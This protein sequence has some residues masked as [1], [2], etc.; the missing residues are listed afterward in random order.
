[1]RRVR[2]NFTP[3]FQVLT[4]GFLIAAI[5]LLAYGGGR[6]Y[7]GVSSAR[8]QNEA[9]RGTL[10]YLQSQVAANDAGGVRIESGP[11]GDM[12]VLPL[13][14][15]EYQTMI[16]LSNGK[17]LEELAPTDVR[18]DPTRAQTISAV[19]SFSAAFAGDHALK[20]S[21]DGRTALVSL[22]AE[23]GGVE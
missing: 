23:G 9:L 1:M 7:R 12:L 15:G 6:L 21:V 4:Y 20:V 19:N 22:H 16:Y 14:S 18:P 2:Q 10:A 17:L 8:T 3:L 11:E 13:S 5:L